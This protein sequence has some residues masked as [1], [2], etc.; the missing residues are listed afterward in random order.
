MFFISPQSYKFN[1]KWKKT[2]INKETNPKDCLREA[3]DYFSDYPKPF[4]LQ[5]FVE[6]TGCN[7]TNS[8]C[9]DLLKNDSRFVTLAKSYLDNEKSFMSE[10]SLFRWWFN[11][12][13]H[14]SENHINKTV[15]TKQELSQN[16]GLLTGKI[17]WK[18]FHNKAVE[19]GEKFGFVFYNPL[20][21]CYTFPLSHLLSH[22]RRHNEPCVQ[23]IEDEL[24]NIERKN[25]LLQMSFP[26]TLT[27]F[28]VNPENFYETNFYIFKQREPYIIESR[29]VKKMTLDEIGKE[30]GVTRE[31][32]RQIER[33]ARYKIP[34][35]L[36]FKI[37]LAEFI[38]KSGRL[39]IE[40]NSNNR[41]YTRFLKSFLE[42]PYTFLQKNQILFWGIDSS[43]DLKQFIPYIYSNDT[44]ELIQKVQDFYPF[45]STKDFNTLLNIIR[46]QPVEKN[47]SV[48]IALKNIGEP[49]HFTEI[50]DM[51]NELFPDKQLS[52]NSVHAT[53]SFYAHPS[54]E[55]HGIVW[56]GTRGT[57][58]LKEWGYERPHRFL[59][60]AI[61][62]IVHRLHKK[63]GKPVS[64]NVILA[65]ISKERGVIN[66]DSVLMAVSFHKKLKKLPNKLFVPCDKEDN[67]DVKSNEEELDKILSA[68]QKNQ[69]KT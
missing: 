63:T 69:E 65:E 2:V 45:F 21:S 48:Y 57:Y 34:L 46:K 29:F 31:R 52:Y 33:V 24:R 3:L 67:S 19:Y 16:M 13:L 36:V 35:S 8:D 1:L 32:V 54:I 38:R 14:L 17:E 62:N 58:A 51:H 20:C 50:A 12:N 10:L 11:L 27:Q 56:V 42:I 49:A 39:L 43:I 68:F 66:P 40:N 4:S 18:E 6:W 23:G 22:I 30:L 55:K 28:M 9:C 60:D 64:Y 59:F 41:L 44:S 15:L 5:D 47:K 37:F 25:N 7:P 61:E 53:L 26:K